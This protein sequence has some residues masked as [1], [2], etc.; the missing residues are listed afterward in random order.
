MSDIQPLSN[1]DLQSMSNN[2]DDFQKKTNMSFTHLKGGYGNVFKSIAEISIVLWVVYVLAYILHVLFF[3]WNLVV[4]IVYKNEI[5]KDTFNTALILFIVGFV[6]GFCFIPSVFFIASICLIYH[7]K[8]KRVKRKKYS[9][10]KKKTKKTKK[11]KKRKR[12][13]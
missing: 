8:N 4:L 12:S 7:G 9:V 10:Q 1:S 3:F 5:S 13:S 11:R 2:L 6:G